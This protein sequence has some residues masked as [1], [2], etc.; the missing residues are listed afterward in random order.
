MV[1]FMV[2]VRLRSWLGFRSG[3]GI[4]Y[5]RARVKVGVSVRVNV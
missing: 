2:R 1:R 5:T 4:L 3:K